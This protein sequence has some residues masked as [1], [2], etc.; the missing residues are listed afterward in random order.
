[1]WLPRASIWRAILVSAAALVGGCFSPD[2]TPGNLHCADGS[3]KCPVGYYCAQS[4]NSCWKDGTSP[5]PFGAFWTSSGGGSGKSGSGAQLS[6]TIGG[7]P[8][9]RIE[10]LKNVSVGY[11]ADDTRP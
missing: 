6:V 7:G 8:G 5:P 3:H 10:G 4:S 2:Y 9:G 1:M 11:F